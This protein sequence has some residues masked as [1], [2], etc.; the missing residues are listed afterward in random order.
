MIEFKFTPVKRW[1]YG[2]ASADHVFLDYGQLKA[3]VKRYLE[4]EARAKPELELP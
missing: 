4:I 2:Q 1:L 3:F